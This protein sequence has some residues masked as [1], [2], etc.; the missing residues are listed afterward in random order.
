MEH[1]PPGLQQD[2]VAKR[3]LFIGATPAPLG[4]PVSDFLSVVSHLYASPSPLYPGVQHQLG[5][6]PASSG[7]VWSVKSLV[8]ED[9]GRG[10][11]AS[12]SWPLPLPREVTM[13]PRRAVSVHQSKVPALSRQLSLHPGCSKCVHSGGSW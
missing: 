2:L 7:W 5:S 13:H 3:W 9:R 10:G 1:S 11:Q 4:L 12:S 6:P 8:S